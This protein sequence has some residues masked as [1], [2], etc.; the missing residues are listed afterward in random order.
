MKPV[1]Y[2]R[3]RE[4]TYLKHFFLERYLERVAYNIGSF[5]GEFVYVDGFSGPWMSEH[6]KFE[7][8]SFIIAIEQLRRV[9]DGLAKT[10]KHPR[11]RCVFVERDQD[12]FGALQRAIADVHDLEVHPIRGEFE[13]AIPEILTRV[14]RSFSL[15]FI[16]PTGWS[17]FGLKR[18]TPILQHQPG[19]VLVNFMFDH[20][21]RFLDDPRPEIAESFA[22]LF[23]GAGWE[24]VIKAGPHREEAIVDFYKERF[25]IAGAFSSVTS[26]RI[27]KPLADR[28]YFYL[29]YGTR[30]PKGL[31]E[32][33]GVEKKA[34]EEQ[35]HIRLSAQQQARIE[36]T[37]QQELF[38]VADDRGGPRS[39]EEERGARIE[40]A[41]VRL[42][43]LLTPGQRVR[44][45]DAVAAVLEIPLVW[46][47][48][49]KDLIATF[50]TRGELEVIG[51][52][53]GQRVPR[54]GCF[55]ERRRGGASESPIRPE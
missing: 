11:I 31:L 18:I 6:E 28:S 17:G 13:D 43:R 33:R 1:E 3:G 15:M 4:Q 14:G 35:E 21:N 36:R 2:Y 46:E 16:D 52:A 55:L 34:V 54:P 29:I 23:G 30:H 45:E 32:F 27:L 42:D 19:E 51:L 47:S 48:D 44:Y 53:A 8:T 10:G 39:F 24:P 12:A 25:R 22:E 9:R 49:L 7:D 37:G 20:I 50:R 40:A 41:R 5:A 26:T 38:S